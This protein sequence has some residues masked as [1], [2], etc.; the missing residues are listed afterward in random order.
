MA[1]KAFNLTTP[2]GG[3]YRRRSWG[4]TPPFT[5]SDCMNVRPD[6]TISG[7]ERIGSRP[8]ID[9]S[10]VLRGVSKSTH[11][12]P[13][14]S[15]HMGSG[16][17]LLLSTVRWYGAIDGLNA[18]RETLVAVAYSTSGA[19]NIYYSHNSGVKWLAAEMG[20]VAHRTT[21][22]PMTSAEINQKLYI[23]DIE[24]CKE[25]DPV[26][27]SVTE[28]VGE[29]D[30]ETNKILHA[31]PTNC[32]IAASYRGRLLL[33]GSQE[34]PHMWYMSKM[35]EPNNWDYTDTSV[36]SAVAGD[37][38]QAGSL[39]EPIQAAIPHGDDCVIFGCAA[40]L[41]T[42][43]S[44]PNYGG[45][46]DNLSHRIGI[47]GRQSWCRSSEG[48]LFM[49]TQD[50]VYAMPPGCGETPRSLSRE[51]VPEE[52][53]F[54][55]AV[56]YGGD[57]F[58]CM[59]YDSVH[60]GVHITRTNDDTTKV[61]NKD[62]GNIHWWMDVK[63]TFT[64]DSGNVASFWPWTTENPHVLPTGLAAGFQGTWGPRKNPTCMGVF[65]RFGGPGKS[66]VMMGAHAG[67]IWRFSDEET[68]LEQ[69]FI[70]LG[71]FP[72]TEQTG[73]YLDGM[74]HQINASMSN[75]SRSVYY[76]IRGGESPEDAM[77]V[78]EV[79][80]GHLYGAHAE[81]L[82]VE[83]HRTTAYNL[84]PNS[85]SGAGNV[86]ER[87]V[88]TEQ[89]SISR[90]RIRAPWFTI[91]IIGAG[92]EEARAKVPGVNTEQIH[93]VSKF[94]RWS[95]ETITAVTEERGKMRYNNRGYTP[96]EF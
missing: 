40:S 57:R 53:V 81:D 9:S 32:L 42:L 93:A 18:W 84:H 50:G 12:T 82:G 67:S 49:L 11:M 63:Q 52:L 62:M 36:T 85:V 33:T 48:W 68:C 17:I 90:P 69:N 4:E 73:L 19:G 44:D 26:T 51:R 1:K 60:R 38:S 6:D 35:N 96:L 8:G 74:L 24:W 3:L 21:D 22:G 27:G 47:S 55:R 46:L 2:M 10:N 94:D 29:I 13:R 23:A 39:G 37:L 72:T 92:G 15:D 75:G 7:R 83:Y 66:D 54:Q 59:E 43:R 78:P 30:A 77:Y 25:F 58:L 71:P 80:K 16:P 20:R 88:W 41:W 64:Q 95:L 65:E 31:A 5:T 56:E 87:G 91:R 45:T 86:L 61:G 76:E 70:V 14:N 28:V 79:D 34:N 89:E